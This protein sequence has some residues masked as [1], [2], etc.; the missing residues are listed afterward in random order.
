MK[1]ML[2][3]LLVTTSVFAAPTMEQINTQVKVLETLAQHDLSC[4]ADS[5]CVA[6]PTGHRPCG[7][8]SMSFVTSKNNSLL[9]EAKR[10]AKRITADQRAFNTAN[11]RI[12]HCGILSI[13]TPV[14]EAQSCK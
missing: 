9:S 7:G 14:C 6:I 4:K 2:L 5:D 3:T 10:M 8:P 11:R 12:S 13:P 1:L